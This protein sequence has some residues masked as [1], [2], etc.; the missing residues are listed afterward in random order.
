MKHVLWFP[1]INAQ[2][3]VSVEVVVDEVDLVEDHEVDLVE[4]VEE[5]QIAVDVMIAVDVIGKF[6]LLTF[7]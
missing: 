7:I 2:E 6:S 1:E 5:D 4:D 3:A